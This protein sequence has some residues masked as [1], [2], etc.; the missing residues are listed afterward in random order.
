MSRAVWPD[1]VRFEREDTLRGSEH[2]WDVAK[3]AT[4][5]LSW[6]VRGRGP[7]PCV[8]WDSCRA[9]AMAMI[10]RSGGTV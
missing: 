8:Q 7:C 10:A 3:Y 6:D 9:E 5:C 1:A 2:R 4:K